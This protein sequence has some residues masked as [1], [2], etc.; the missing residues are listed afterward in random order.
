MIRDVAT[1][2]QSISRHPLSLEDYLRLDEE[3]RKEAEVVEGVLVSREQR[4]RAHQKT[5]FRLAE[6]MESSAAKF[7]R[8]HEGGGT[9]PC[10][11]VNT[12]VE[13]VLWEV[14]LTLRKPDCVV[15]R[16]LTGF[17]RLTAA[18]VAV[19]IEVVSRWSQARD[20]IHKKG[21]YAQAGIPHYLIVQYDEAGAVSVE[22]YALV[23]AERSYSEISTT[24][25]DRDVFAISMSTPFPVQVLWQ[26][27]ET[28]PR[29]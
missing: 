21:E 27:L 9:S 5:G 10:Y 1:N 8:V 28:A 22:H 6:A 24:H 23:G 19:A 3:I 15:H 16:C 2:W 4:D 11:E 17:E 13:L 18:D 25:R 29:D 14:P 7:R 12:E 26:D 20:R